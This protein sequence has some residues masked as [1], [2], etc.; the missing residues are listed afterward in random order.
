MA[1]T[2][3]ELQEV[4]KS[5]EVS[6]DTQNLVKPEKESE[7]S[8]KAKGTNGLLVSLTGK[9]HKCNARGG[10][11]IANGVQLSNDRESSLLEIPGFTSWRSS[12]SLLLLPPALLLLWS[13]S[14]WEIS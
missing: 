1:T 12:Q 14:S 2:T 3:L 6:E 11:G 9:P 8:S 5:A 10:D 13:T 4:E 7:E